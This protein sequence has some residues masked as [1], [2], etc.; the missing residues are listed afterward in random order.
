MKKLYSSFI[1]SAAIAFS[2]SSVADE[3][4]YMPHSGDGPQGHMME[5]KKHKPGMDESHPVVPTT[6]AQK[7]S[8]TNEHYMPHSG[9]GP[10]GHTMKGKN[11]PAG[12]SSDHVEKYGSGEHSKTEGKHYMMEG[13]DGPQG[14]MMK[15]DKHPSNL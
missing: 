15:G 14:Q 3:K 1:I 12:A 13:G 11:H 8:S 4:H 7:A 6:K 2:N 9:D 5:G 10:Q